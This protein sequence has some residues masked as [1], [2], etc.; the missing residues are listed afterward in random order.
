[1]PSESVGIMNLFK[2]KNSIGTERIEQPELGSHP[3]C[4]V[5][6]SG[7]GD[8][9]ARTDHGGRW[10]QIGFVERVEGDFVWVS[11]ANPVV[12][13][14]AFPVGANHPGPWKLWR[15]FGDR[16]EV[17]GV[18]DA[19]GKTVFTANGVGEVSFS[20]PEAERLVLAAPQ[21]FA[22]VVEMLTVVLPEIGPEMFPSA[23]ADFA[24]KCRHLVTRVLAQPAQPA[25]RPSYEE[26]MTSLR[27]LA[28]M[29]DVSDSVQAAYARTL[30]ARIEQEPH[31]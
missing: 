16:D 1:M 15:Q 13:V 31:V 30:I 14:P 29:D 17:S 23:V 6:P 27:Q 4:F 24:A 22:L 20:T 11:M 8:T 12:T 28:E 2:F 9:A 5:N 7:D 3:P 25:G 21:S 26:L 19:D 18:E 10:P